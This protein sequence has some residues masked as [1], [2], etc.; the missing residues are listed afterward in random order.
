MTDIAT[1]V[2]LPIGAFFREGWLPLT[3]RDGKP[4]LTINGVEH[5]AAELLRRSSLDRIRQCE[6]CL[7]VVREDEPHSYDSV[8][9]L[10]FC[11]DCSPSY[12]DMLDD[13]ASFYDDDEEPMK[14][15]KA[16][17]IVDAHLAAGGQITDK[18]VRRP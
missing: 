7:K 17:A 6:G 2:A 15:E 10:T 1:I 4:I 11:E 18:M 8:N 9:G 12:Q 14:P 16:K 5:D 13:P 3:Y